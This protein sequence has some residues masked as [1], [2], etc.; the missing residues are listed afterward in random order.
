LHG[1][2]QIGAATLLRVPLYLLWKIPIYLRLM[3]GGETRWV[4]T[5]RDGE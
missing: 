3:R 5:E 4:R 1:R 2:A